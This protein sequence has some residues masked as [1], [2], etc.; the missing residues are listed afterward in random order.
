MSEIK[1]EENLKNNKENS[2]SKFKLNKDL[3]NEKEDIMRFYEL[4]DEGIREY[5]IK[6]K[7]QLLQ[8]LKLSL[9]GTAFGFLASMIFDSTFKKMD[10]NKKDII[11]A[12]ILTTSVMFCTFQGYRVSKIQLI[13]ETNK[14]CEEYGKEIK[15]EKEK[16]KD[17]I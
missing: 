6:K 16:N 13:K 2:K 5:G 10:G 14:L 11:K 1:K 4:N 3:Y 7:K 9:F 17:L 8:T 12:C 15:L